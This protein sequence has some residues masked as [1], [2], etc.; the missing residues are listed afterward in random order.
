M[1]YIKIIF[2]FTAL[3]LRG[4]LLIAQQKSSLNAVYSGITWFDDEHRIVSAHGGCI[5]RDGNKFYLFGEKHL[6]DSNAFAGFNCYSSRDLYNWKFERIA[7]AAQQTGKLGPNRVGE[8]V[9]VVKCPATGEYVMLMHV[10]TL[11]YTDQFI[12]YATSKT[13]TGPYAFR[14]PLLF[15]GKPIRKWDM[16]TFQDSDGSGY[17]LLHGGDIYKLGNDYKSATEHICKS[18]T[19]GFEAPAMFK[20]GDTYYFLG[21]NLSS[22]EKNDNYYYTST[23]LQ[24][25]WLSGGL[26]CPVGTL[27]WNSQG[28]FVLP[29]AGTKDTSYIFMGDRWSYPK[30]ASAATYV[31]QPITFSGKALTIPAY[32][33]AWKVNTATG[34]VIPDKPVMTDVKNSNNKYFTFSGKWSRL[35]ADSLMTTA[36]EK[37]DSFTIKFTGKQAGFSGMLR[38]D[39]GYASVELKD[40]QGKTVLKTLVDTY[41]KY[42]TKAILFLTPVL[43]KNTY[44][45]TVTL[46]GEHGTWTNK[47]KAIFGSTGNLFA[48][49]K[50]MIDER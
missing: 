18:F 38:P 15:E 13:V 40:R 37:N 32:I 6:D 33:P 45:L 14:G 41:C 28:T 1:K 30:Q 11:G 24:G 12:G 16:G 4:S 7:L 50:A 22:W 43:T 34:Q 47:R 19:A 39:G 17:V 46:L 21:S 25:P 8:R 29:I 9:K 23:S 10:D 31:W 36:A 3:F 20:K 26:F 2:F 48:L 42:P 27:S 44:K 35:S 49:D 5:V